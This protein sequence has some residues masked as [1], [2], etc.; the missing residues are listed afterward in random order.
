MI[1]NF[2]TMK[3][4]LLWMIVAILTCG[5][6]FTSCI[7][8]EDNPVPAAPSLPDQTS[9]FI[10]NVLAD[11]RYQPDVL[12]VGAGGEKA[13]FLR[14]D[15]ADVEEA[16]AEF[17]KLLPEGVAATAFEAQDHAKMFTART[18]YELTHPQNAHND[19]IFFQTLNPALAQLGVAWVELADEMKKAFNADFIIYMPKSDNDD[20]VN[21]V[22]CLTAIVPF[23]KPDPEDR[24]HLI[25]TITR[26]QQTLTSDFM[27]MKMMGTAAVNAN[28]DLELILTD[29]AGKSYGKMIIPSRDKLT[30][31]AFNRFLFDE[32]LQA[33]MAA[34]IGGAFSKITFLLAEE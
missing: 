11:T 5:S 34:V 32:D 21:F 1:Q 10:Q 23:G 12:E 33:S 2:K 9:M 14:L 8:N 26:A 18:G 19:T 3:Q 4:K 7:K 24:S 16:T 13:T 22:K 30:D 15:V 6:V 20:M 28:G 29:S 31:G 17:L 25:C 27:T